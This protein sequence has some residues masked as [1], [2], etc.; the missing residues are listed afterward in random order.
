[1]GGKEIGVE[2]MKIDYLC[3]LAELSLEIANIVDRHGE[4]GDF[5]FA[6][7]MGL[8]YRALSQYLRRG[9]KEIIDIQEAYSNA[10]EK[11][12][13]AETSERDARD[14]LKDI[15]GDEDVD[16]LSEEYKS[17]IKDFVSGLFEDFDTE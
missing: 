16:S 10:K 15:F 9:V 12:E 6:D 13:L 1:M 7:E 11:A 4:N 8:G 2:K 14:F 17:Q 5:G 3:K